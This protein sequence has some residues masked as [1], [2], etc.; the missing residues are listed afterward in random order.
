VSTTA[1]GSL[2]EDR[3]RLVTVGGTAN[4]VAR[5]ERLLEHHPVGAFVVDVEHEWTVELGY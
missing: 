3:Q 5:R 2:G 1:T 4:A